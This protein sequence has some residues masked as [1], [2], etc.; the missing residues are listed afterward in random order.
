VAARL[1]ALGD[2]L[3]DHF[4]DA[5]RAGGASWC[6]IGCTLGTSKQAAHERFGALADPPPGQAP[7]RLTGAAADVLS[8]AADQAR[9][10]GHH[11]V[12]PQTKRLLEL[13]LAIAKSLGNRCPK[14]EH[15]L[16]AATSPKLHSSAAEL[17][18]ELGASPERAR[19]QLTRTL[20]AEAPELA[21]R[22]T[23]RSRLAR[24]RMRSL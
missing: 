6:E 13:A 18:A 2:E 24:F 11:F 23:G 12:A 21:E 8:V 9:G 22:L 3:L 15:I 16:L 1:C 17:L 14:T 7:F 4:V 19:D 5:A 20:L 10:L